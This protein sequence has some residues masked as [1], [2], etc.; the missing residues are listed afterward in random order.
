METSSRLGEWMQVLGNVVSGSKEYSPDQLLDKFVMEA[1]KIALILVGI[2]TLINLVSSLYCWLWYEATTYLYLPNWNK[3]LRDVD[4][5]SQRLEVSIK[6]FVGKFLGMTKAVVR[7][8]M[9]LITFVPQIWV[10]SVHY[11]FFYFSEVPGK[12][13]WIVLVICTFGLA[14]TA[15]FGINLKKCRYDINDAEAIYRSALEFF[16]RNKKR[17]DAVSELTNKMIEMRKKN[18]RLFYNKFWY[19][20]WIGLYAQLWAVLPITFFGYNVFSGFVKYGI[21]SKTSYALGEVI[22][23]LSTPIWLYEEFT[24]IKS[25]AQRITELEKS[26][27]NPKNWEEAKKEEGWE[28]RRRKTVTVDAGGRTVELSRGDLEKILA[29]FDTLPDKQN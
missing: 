29:N 8:I 10:L 17:D 3:T 7:S 23:A 28:D 13:F 18:L 22:G 25:V 6:E 16:Q 14:I 27:N 24:A 12:L 11:N 19:D 4:G 21:V 20:L 26:I 2:A 5:P 15:I 9:V 1:A